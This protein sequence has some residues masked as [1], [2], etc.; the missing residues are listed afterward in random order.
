M[1]NYAYSPNAPSADVIAMALQWAQRQSDSGSTN[2][3]IVA[4]GNPAVAL[5]AQGGANDPAGIA[6][7]Y[8]QAICDVIL[9]QVGYQGVQFSQTNNANGNNTHSQSFVDG[10]F[11]SYTFNAPLTK[12][13]LVHVD[14]TT[15]FSA[16]AASAN[17]QCNFGLNIDGV[18]HSD[19]GWFVHDNRTG[20]HE[21]CSFRYLAAL[22]A[23]SHTIKL[24]WLTDA[25]TTSMASAIGFDFCQ[26]VI[27]G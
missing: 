9:A 8:F 10:P 19:S 4:N 17:G 16:I 6:T 27:T 23:G 14:V 13:Y 5:L 2:G 3:G 22:A 12:N 1:A 26:L 24:R 15:Y 25:S 18:D 7:A 21:R 11:A 20:I